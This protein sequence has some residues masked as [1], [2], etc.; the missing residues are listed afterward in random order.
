MKPYRGQGACARAFTLV[1]LLVVVAIISIL[2]GLLLPALQHA[3]AAAQ[4]MECAN[5]ERQLGLCVFLFVDDHGGYL[6]CANYSEN[7]AY[8]H[9]DEL[10]PPMDAVS[11]QIRGYANSLAANSFWSY[12]AEADGPSCRSHPSYATTRSVFLSNRDGGG[13]WWK[14]AG[15]YGIAGA[16]F[17]SWYKNPYVASDIKSLKM[18]LGKRPHPSILFMA[19]ESPEPIG[20]SR[21]QFPNKGYPSSYSRIGFYHQGD[22]GSNGLYFDGHV[23]FVALDHE[24]QYAIDYENNYIV[25]GGMK[26]ENWD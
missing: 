16:H 1:E 11:G 8:P 19:I 24:I 7:K 9:G 25:T 3:M 21:L 26:K 18:R 13:E 2:A 12:F 15:N 10:F 20:A 5:N 17:S 22:T 4:T 14:L 23:S 6:P